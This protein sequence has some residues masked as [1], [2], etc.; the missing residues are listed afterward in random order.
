MEDK[1]TAYAI[2]LII[3]VVMVY[4]EWVL[5]P[6]TRSHAPAPAAVTPA[7]QGV[8][9]TTQMGQ[10]PA[11][12]P[13][14]QTN[15][16]P[17]IGAA[18]TVQHASPVQIAESSKLTVENSKMIV[19]LTA[20]GGRVSNVILKEYRERLGDVK[21]LDL[22][23]NFEGIE[24]PLGIHA[25]GISDELVNYTVVPSSASVASDP[26]HFILAGKGNEL[27]LQFRGMLSN[28]IDIQK[29]VRFYPDSYLFNV[30]VQLGMPAPGGAS[31]WL[32]WTKYLT[33]LSEDRLNPEKFTLFTEAGKIKQV[34][35]AEAAATSLNSALGL[36]WLGFNDKYF[37]TILVPSVGGL[38]ASLAKVNNA[39][40]E[41]VRGK[42]SE[43]H[44]VV[45]AGPKEFETLKAAGLDL[46]RD[47][48]L[49]F[50]SFLAY[51]LLLLLRLLDSL[52]SNYGLA[53][54][55]LTLIVKA[56]FLPLT[57]TSMKSMRAMQA[58]QPE[59]KDLRERIKDPTELNQAM[60]GLYKK[61][62]V[63]PM[64]GCL[65]IVIQI[66]VF[67][68]LYSALQNA[69]ELRHAPFALWIHDLSAPER[70]LL[71]G[72][73]VPVMILLMGASMLLQQYLTPAPTMDPSQRKMMLW[74]T[75]AF[76]IGFLLYPFPAGLALYMLVNS[77][78]SLVQQRVIKS[79][80][81]ASPFRATALASVGIF[82]IAFL[83]TRF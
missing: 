48:D 4:S 14:A 66:P 31:L 78:I 11:V 77:T 61:H 74:M 30:D 55:L 33:P 9:P 65:P 2:F 43:G 58:L 83:M 53:T 42:E 67:F 1:R 6:Y 35:L 10:Q 15:G 45:Y 13:A 69:I 62:G 47:I 39:A 70:L 23:E 81:N 34:Q 25:G 27:A 44:F 52:V 17:Q 46:E 57:L 38:N 71:F 36:R 3:V 18:T 79:E 29:T 24:L 16:V 64:G 32:E 28:D 82:M 51:P 60:M 73:N 72:I 80:S 21:P 20:L 49:G 5:A 54:V 37:T 56:A 7:T 40:I 22:V 41:R 68:G 19:T 76:T 59:M 8:A 12:N 50:F 75:G 26:S 63:N